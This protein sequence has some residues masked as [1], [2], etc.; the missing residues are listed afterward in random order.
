MMH[1]SML[2]A[3]HHMVQICTACVDAG[4]VRCACMLCAA[5]HAARCILEFAHSIFKFRTRSLSVAQHSPP[6]ALR[7]IPSDWR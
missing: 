2:H 1:G 4:A 5:V 7:R 6:P 3:L